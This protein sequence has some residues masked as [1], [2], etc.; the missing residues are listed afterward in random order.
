MQD[1]DSNVINVYHERQSQIASLKTCLEHRAFEMQNNNRLIQDLKNR[2]IPYVKNLMD[3]VGKRFTLFFAQM[4]DGCFG[5][6]TLETSGAISLSSSYLDIN[7]FDRWELCIRVRFRPDEPLQ[8]LSSFRQS[9]GEKSLS[10]MLFLLSL[11]DPKMQKCPFRV[12]DEINQGIFID[13]FSGMDAFN[14]RRIHGLIS[15]TAITFTNSQ[16]SKSLMF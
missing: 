11:Q 8:R 3:D 6:V 10:T 15:R 12:V 5:E 16:Y 4:R 1:L 14:E 7:D 13:F 9:G 2:W